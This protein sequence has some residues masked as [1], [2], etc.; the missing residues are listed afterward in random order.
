M[1]SKCANPECSRQFLYLHQGKLFQLAP[2]PE[3]D[4]SEA[5]FDVL[6]ERFWLCDLCS[7]SMSLVWDRNQA[8]I[9]KLPAAPD[10]S[11]PSNNTE[12]LA[13]KQAAHAGRQS[14]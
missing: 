5:T 11:L 10:S 14:R 13:K 8:R 7:K 1:L 6:H 12:G 2:T 3:V 4:S 9:V